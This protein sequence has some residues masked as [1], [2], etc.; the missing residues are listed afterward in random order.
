MLSLS[1]THLIIYF[2]ILN[3]M[4]IISIKYL[5]YNI[6]KYCLPSKWYSLIIQNFSYFPLSLPVLINR[7]PKISYLPIMPK[8]NITDLS[9]NNVILRAPKLHKLTETITSLSLHN[10]YARNA[11]SIN[12]IHLLFQTEVS[13]L[14]KQTSWFL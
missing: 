13:F 4:Y 8:R 9:S 7:V 11:Q 12:D 6:P 10:N 1:Y 14:S 2:Y 3:C 5:F